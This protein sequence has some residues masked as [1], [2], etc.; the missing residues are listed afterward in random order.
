MVILS[1]SPPVFS[2]IS[3]DERIGLG[4]CRGGVGL[5]HVERLSLGKKCVFFCLAAYSL[6]IWA[7]RFL[8][9]SYS[10]RNVDWPFAAAAHLIFIL[11]SLWIISR[12]RARR[13]FGDLHER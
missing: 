10:G 8:L 3:G 1:S 6:Y 2:S 9:P 11:A 4:Y 12:A 13:F 5:W 7:D